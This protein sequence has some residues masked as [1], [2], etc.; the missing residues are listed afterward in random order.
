[1][2]S[3]SHLFKHVSLHSVSQMAKDLCFCS[4]HMEWL[5]SI[6]PCFF[7]LRLL[8]KLCLHY[9]RHAHLIVAKAYR[10]NTMALH[11]LHEITNYLLK[12]SRVN[13]L[14]WVLVH[15]WTANDIKYWP[16][17]VLEGFQSKL[18]TIVL[19]CSSWGLDIFEVCQGIVAESQP[20]TKAFWYWSRAWSKDLWKTK[21]IK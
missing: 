15:H 20:H 10:S 2:Y 17:P 3:P 9:V 4:V 14:R 6:L 16:V 21:I 12:I 8:D 18:K 11:Y 1:M 5:L 13:I 7:K 19:S